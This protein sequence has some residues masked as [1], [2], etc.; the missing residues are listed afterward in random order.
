MSATFWVSR[1]SERPLRISSSGLKR[2][3]SVA[4]GSNRHVAAELPSPS[5][6]QRPVLLLDVVD[7]HRVR[8][9]EERRD[10]EAHALAAAGRREAEDVL[11]A[12]VADERSEARRRVVRVLPAA[13]DGRSKLGVVRLAEDDARLAQQARALR[14]PRSS[15]SASY[16]GRGSGRGLAP[17]GRHRGD[18]PAPARAASVVMAP[19]LRKSV[20]A[21]DA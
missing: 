18:A 17:Q 1:T 11:G 21:R 9:G 6:R 8:P 10:D 3:E 19:A 2:T 4:V 15:P 14:S 5:G 20:G 7:E 13:V 12:V 16:R